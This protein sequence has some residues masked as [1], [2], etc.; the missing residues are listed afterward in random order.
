MLEHMHGDHAIEGRIGPRLPLLDVNAED[1]VGRKLLDELRAERVP[2]LETVVRL[3]GEI[4]E[5][6]VLP[7]LRSDFERATSLSDRQSSNE[8]MLNFSML[9]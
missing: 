2:A 8:A 9:L 5:P 7:E 6:A 3:T 1:P 4:L